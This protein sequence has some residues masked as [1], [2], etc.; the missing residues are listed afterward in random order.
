M[1]VKPI[2]F[3]A[4][5]FALS[6]SI[7]IPLTLSHFGVGPF[8]IAESTSNIVRLLGVLMPAVSAIILTAHIGG[9][10]ALLNLFSCLVFWR[11]HWKWWLAAVAGQPILLG[12][13]ALIYNLTASD[14]TI[15]PEAPASYVVF[16]VNVII[17]LI[18]TLGEE[19]GW[20]GV[21]L[22]G[23]QQ[24]HSAFRSSLILGLL[25]AAWHIPF[26]LL[27]DSFDQFGSSYL[28]LNFLFVLPLTFY[29]TWFFN[30]SSQSVLL[31]VML[32]LTFNIVNTILLPVTINPG[33]F[34]I[35]GA[36]EWIVA[37]LII[38]HLEPDVERQTQQSRIAPVSRL[39]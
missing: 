30:H 39:G 17:L 27:L 38:K 35:F 25:W 10:S 24:Q 6:W 29:I 3:F 14:W 20:R 4:L 36:L 8:H 32:H 37:I 18:A 23:L 12:L 13:A 19:I 2:K 5:T 21:A 15:V 26:W 11:V 16:I 34:V 33:A 28:L 1:T 22:P 31:A 7:W 9:R